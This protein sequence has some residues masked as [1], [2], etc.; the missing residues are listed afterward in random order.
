MKSQSMTMTNANFKKTDYSQIA[1]QYDQNDTRHQI[2]KDPHLETHLESWLASQKDEAF[3]V[4]DLACGTGNW[5][6]VQTHHFKTS[7]IHWHGLDA[8][9]DMLQYAR[10]KS[11]QVSWVQG[12]ADLLPYD[13]QSFNFI[14]NNFAFH[15]FPDKKQSLRELKRVLKTNGLLKIWNISPHHMKEMWV[16][17]FFPNTWWEDMKRFWDPALFFYELESLGFIV[18]STIEIK[19]SRMHLSKI[20]NEAENR[21]ISELTLI[22]EDEYQQGLERIKA[23]L[24]HNPDASF[25]HDLALETHICKITK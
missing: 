7:S 8:S 4:L 11:P 24:K 6:K 13:D 1:D 20:L 18:S 21:D 16:Y 10:P 25:I 19:R 12:T 14:T 22:S 5:L 2:P 15:H 23:E 3:C 17:H 9:A